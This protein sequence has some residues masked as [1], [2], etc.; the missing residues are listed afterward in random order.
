[1]SKEGVQ[2]PMRVLIWSINGDVGK[3][4][5]SLN[6]YHM[7]GVPIITNEIY[8]TLTKVIQTEGDLM[9]L[10]ENQPVPEIP[11]NY[12]IIFD[13]AGGIQKDQKRII[14]AIKQVDYIMVPTYP[15]EETL[16]YRNTARE[17]LKELHEV[18]EALGLKF[19]TMLVINK[20]TNIK[21][22]E[23][24]KEYFEKLKKEN[25]SIHFDYIAKLKKSKALCHIY[26]HNQ[27]IKDLKK[28]S[29]LLGFSYNQVEKDFDEI[30]NIIN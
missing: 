19:K 30:L 28:S 27:S 10:K 20:Y 25:T 24:E 14:S 7:L 18:K 4:S 11:Q 12:S 17:S 6:L 26:T 3:T 29:P 23:A 2:K 1:M 9:I 15:E 13:F 5:I 21:E 8:T 16:K 22:F